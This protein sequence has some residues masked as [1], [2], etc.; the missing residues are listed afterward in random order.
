MLRI[1]G[2]EVSASGNPRP[3]AWRVQPGDLRLGDFTVEPDLS[4]AGPF[5]AAALVTGGSVTVADWPSDSL[6]ASDAIVDVLT[7]MGASC[8]LGP[9]GLTVTGSGAIRGIE[10][11]LRDIP[12]L[13]LPLASVA[14]ASLGLLLGKQI[15]VFFPLWLFV[16]LGLAPMPEGANWRQ[17]YGVSLLCGVGFTMS[18][19]I[20]GLAFEAAGV[21]APVRL[22]VLGGSVLS[23]IAGYCVL[24]FAAKAPSKP[25][26]A[27][28]P[29]PAARP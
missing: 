9:D 16:R 8:S 22:G 15:G 14:M 18:L 23:A 4:N 13:C 6:Q 7:R 20:G 11:D 28:E 5:L 10:A 3:N 19:F 17:L 12:E 21:D 29:V 2:A 1:A 24:R 27:P 26:A 25:P